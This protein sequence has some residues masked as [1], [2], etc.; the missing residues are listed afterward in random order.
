MQVKAFTKQESEW[1]AEKKVPETLSRSEPHVERGTRVRARRATEARVAEVEAD[2]AMVL[3][4]QARDLKAGFAGDHKGIA[5]IETREQLISRA[6]CTA[7]SATS[8]LLS[9]STSG[10]TVRV[11][12][13]RITSDIIDRLETR[14]G[15][16]SSS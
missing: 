13:F 10:R 14:P 9:T 2:K 5:P 3:G 15:R 4:D 12:I 8:T 7:D 11:K 6:I 1:E 16:S